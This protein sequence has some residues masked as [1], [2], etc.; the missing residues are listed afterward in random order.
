MVCLQY[1][2]VFEAGVEVL[3]KFCVDAALE[4]SAHVGLRKHQ[5]LDGGV[6]IALN[7]YM[8]DLYL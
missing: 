5:M 4:W 6:S 3:A 7:D 2:V 1:I 8:V